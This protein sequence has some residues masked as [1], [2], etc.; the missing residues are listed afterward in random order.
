[1]PI[2]IERI[3]IKCKTGKLMYPILDIS[4]LWNSKPFTIL[5]SIPELILFDYKVKIT[6]FQY[7]GNKIK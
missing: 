7:Y 4:F 6:I 2:I 1:M 3:T 5:A